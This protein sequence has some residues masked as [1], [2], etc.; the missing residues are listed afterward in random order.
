MIGCGVIGEDLL[1]QDPPRTKRQLR[2]QGG[3]G[4]T[5][6]NWKDDL[7]RVLGKHKTI[8]TIETYNCRLYPFTYSGD[9][10]RQQMLL[11]YSAIRC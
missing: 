6:P 11:T 8:A 10:Q 7:D 4:Q 9:T 3:N 5:W 1:D 2:D